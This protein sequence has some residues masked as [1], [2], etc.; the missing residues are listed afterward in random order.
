MKTF[1]NYEALPVKFLKFNLNFNLKIHPLEIVLRY[2][3]PQL[4]VVENYSYLSNLGPKFLLIVKYQFTSQKVVFGV[5]TDKNVLIKSGVVIRTVVV[6]LSKHVIIA[7]QI[8]VYMCELTVLVWGRPAC[9][10]TAHPPSVR[11]NVFLLSGP[12]PSI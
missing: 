5:I 1:H 2:R 9:R 4:Q 3:D 7:C 8:L 10:Q 12:F 11:R 6:V